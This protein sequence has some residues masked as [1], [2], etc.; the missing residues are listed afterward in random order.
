MKKAFCIVLLLAAIGAGIWYFLLRSDKEQPTSCGIEVKVSEAI[1]RWDENIPEKAEAIQGDLD[2]TVY[3][4]LTETTECYTACRLFL[5]NDIS[6]DKYLLLDT[7]GEKQQG[8]KIP[9]KARNKLAYGCDEVD[10][11]D[12]VTYEDGYIQAVEYVIILTPTKILLEGSPDCRNMYSYIL[13]LETYTAIH[14]E[15]YSGFSGMAFRDGADYLDFFSPDYSAGYRQE[16][17]EQYD[18]FGNLISREPYE[19]EDY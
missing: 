15:A 2:W 13:D 16:Y 6:H 18:L 10:Y 5:E 17:I 9:I 1:Q 4:E 3:Q 19:N 8:T 11:K 7:R 12:S 14:V